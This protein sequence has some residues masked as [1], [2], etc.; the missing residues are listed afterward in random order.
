MVAVARDAVVL[1]EILMKRSSR[2]PV[3]NC[4][5]LRRAHTDVRE[6]V[7]TDAV[8]G[9]HAAPTGMTGEA[10]R[11]ELGVSVDEWSRTDH[12]VRIEKCQCHQRYQVGADDDENPTALHFHPQNRS[13]DTM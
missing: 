9:V 7:A 10:V 3:R 6:A 2:L 12:Q 8:L 4:S 13:I 11:R 1:D 5:A